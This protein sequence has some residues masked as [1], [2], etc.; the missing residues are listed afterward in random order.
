[1]TKGAEILQALERHGPSFLSR[2][3]IADILALLIK[4]DSQGNVT[5]P[6]NK[7]ESL[8]R[9]RVLGSDQAALSRHALAIVVDQPHPFA[10][11]IPSASHAPVAVVQ[12]PLPPFPPFDIDIGNFLLSFSS[13]GPA[14]V[15]KPPSAPIGPES[16]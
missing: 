5:K 15:A 9:V 10:Y 2:L 1:M 16:M 3:V 13:F 6:K 8:D 4:A 11:P 14:G 7:T 12:Q